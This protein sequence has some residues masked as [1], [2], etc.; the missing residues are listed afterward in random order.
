[1]DVKSLNQAIGAIDSVAWHEGNETGSLGP[2]CRNR[3]VLAAVRQ[4]LVDVRAR[5]AWDKPD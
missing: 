1:M 2:E 3:L 5:S 4:Y